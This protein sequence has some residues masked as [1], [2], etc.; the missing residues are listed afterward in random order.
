MSCFTQWGGENEIRAMSLLYKVDFVVFNAQK[1]TKTIITNN[2]FEKKIYLCHTPPR[3][4][5]AVYTQEY[6]SNAAFCQCNYA[7]IL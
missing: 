6:I 3:Q 4:Y 7:Y 1:F 5:D 2:G